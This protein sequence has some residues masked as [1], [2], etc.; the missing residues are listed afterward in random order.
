MNCLLR[1]GCNWFLFLCLYWLLYFLWLLHRLLWLLLL[2]GIRFLL[3]FRLYQLL[4]CCWLNIF[5][6]LYFLFFFA[7][8]RL[9]NLLVI[10][11]LFFSFLFLGWSHVFLLRRLRIY[12]KGRHSR[13]RRS[14]ILQHIWRRPLWLLILLLF[15][16]HLL[17][18]WRLIISISEY[19]GILGFIDVNVWL[20]SIGFGLHVFG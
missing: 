13:L 2:L 8:F 20:R 1:F 4:L 9:F 11:F 15:L 18:V 16:G 7:E 3:W 6:D 10:F 12:L 17:N 14:L 19:I 5:F